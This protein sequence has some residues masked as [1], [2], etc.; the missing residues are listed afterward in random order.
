M[1]RFVEPGACKMR[2]A[3]GIVAICLVPSQRL[4][5]LICLPAFNA[6][7]PDTMFDKSVIKH[8]CHPT[9]LKDNLFTRRTI[10]QKGGNRHRR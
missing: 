8:R 3:A 9:G 7:N 10:R 4:Q 6:D 5:C 1:C 2:Q